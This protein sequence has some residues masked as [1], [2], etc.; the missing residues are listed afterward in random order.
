MA[1][2]PAKLKPLGTLVAAAAAAGVPAG[3][4][5]LAQPLGP[6]PQTTTV[7]IEGGI[8]FSNYWRSTVPGGALSLLPPVTDPDKTGSPPVSNG[9]NESRHNTGGYGSFSVGQTINPGLDWRFSVAMF[10]FGTTRASGN[11][12]Q[13]FSGGEEPFTNTASITE[14]NRFAFQTVDF[15]FGRTWSGGGFQFRAFGGL[16]GLYTIDRFNVAI[17]TEGTD[18]VGLLTV[19][20]TTTNESSIGSSHFTGV[21]PRAGLDFSTCTPFG[22]VGSVSGAFL[23]GVRSS[24]FDRMT[25]VFDGT[26]TSITQIQLSDNKADWVGNLSGMIGASWQFA[27]TGQFVVGYKLDQWFNIRD[28]FA[29]AGFNNKQDV[30][31]QTPFFKVILRY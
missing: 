13:D 12:S 24:H 19:L 8:A 29:F 16:R 21:G 9:F 31:V 17:A 15:D 2:V 23:G 6:S 20:T 11:A 1:R 18:K 7:T 26:T 4:G 30:L 25:T 27:P 28:S 3:D 10:D 14:S 5:A 22:L